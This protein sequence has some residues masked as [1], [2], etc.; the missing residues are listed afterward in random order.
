[1]ELKARKDMNPKDQWD[2]SHIFPTMKEWQTAFDEVEAS[3]PLLKGFTGTLGNIQKA[4]YRTC[5]WQ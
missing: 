2:V 1:M 4:C 5:A 3:I